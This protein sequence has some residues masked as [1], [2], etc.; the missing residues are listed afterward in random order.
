M[1]G[2]VCISTELGSEHTKALV[3]KLV[4]APHESTGAAVLRSVYN[5]LVYSC[6][7]TN[8]WYVA[9]THTKWEVALL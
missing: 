2:G 5:S 4:F 7:E 6:S 8:V 9:H 1:G 3:W